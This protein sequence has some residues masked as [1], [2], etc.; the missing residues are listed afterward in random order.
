MEESFSTLLES[1]LGVYKHVLLRQ[2]YFKF[3][4]SFYETIAYRPKPLKLKAPKV[5]VDRKPRPNPELEIESKVSQ[6]LETAKKVWTGGRRP[7][8]KR[9]PV[10]Q[11]E[12]P[13]LEPTPEPKEQPLFD[14]ELMETYQ[15]V[16]SE[17]N[18][19]YFGGKGNLVKAKKAE[20]AAKKSFLTKL[21]SK[22][23]PKKQENDLD[24]KVCE[25]YSVYKL[26]KE[27]QM[28]LSDQDI[29][30]SFS[31]LSKLPQNRCKDPEVAT[32]IF[33]SYYILEWISNELRNIENFNFRETKEAISTLKQFL[34]HPAATETIERPESFNSE[35]QLLKKLQEA[36]TKEEVDSIVAQYKEL[37]HW[38]VDAEVTKF[39]L[40]NQEDISSLE[41][42]KTLHSIICKDGKTT[43]T[44]SSLIS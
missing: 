44:L 8:P 3:V 35:K 17:Y 41:G 21:H 36:C 31:N 5:P 14:P 15:Q 33:K 27:I 12:P 20:N 39:Y 28:I 29:M 1:L 42:F 16:K 6:A 24:Q 11:P 32:Q 4:N 7:A 30:Q 34:F 40:A 25:A 13:K 19:S 2:F 37:D 38:R 43:C 9:V 10:R 26:L 22:F 18:S 23:P